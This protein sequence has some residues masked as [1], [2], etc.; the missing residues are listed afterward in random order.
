MNIKDKQYQEGD[1][2]LLY[3]SRYK[4]FKGKLRTR[5]LGPY[6]IEKIHD[7]GSVQ[8]RTIDEE[9]IPLLVNGYKLKF[10]K[11]P[12]SD[13]EFING[14]NKTVMVVDQVSTSTSSSH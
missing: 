6:V 4:Y 7:N 13:Q 1:W 8:I 2:A 5:R 10:Y 12:L 11:K 3:D 14:I 9:A